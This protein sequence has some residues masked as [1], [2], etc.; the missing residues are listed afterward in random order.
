MKKV[1][2][3]LFSVLSCLQMTAQTRPVKGKVTDSRDGSVLLGVSVMVKGTTT[4]TT[5]NVDGVY[6]LN[7]ADNAT[8][9]FNFVG[10]EVLEVPVSGKST[11][12]IQ[13]NLDVKTLAEFEIST[14]YVSKRKGT[15]TGAIDVIDGKR[16]ESRPSG[17]FNHLLQGQAAGV[18]VM[19]NGGRPGAAPQIFIRGTGSINSGLAPLYIVDGQPVSPSDFATISQNDIESFNILKDAS[20]TAVYGSRG[21]NGVIL[22]TT[23]RGKSGK[24]TLDYRGFYGVTEIAEP[25]VRMMNTKERLDYEVAIGLRQANDPAI[26]ELLKSDYN[27]VKEILKPAL[28]QSHTISVRTGTDKTS[29]YMS[30]EYYDQ[31]GVYYDNDFSRVGARLNVDNTTTDWLKTGLNMYVGYMEEALPNETRNSTGNPGMMA[32]LVMPYENLRSES[33]NWREILRHGGYTNVRSNL[34]SRENDFTGSGNDHLKFLG[35]VFAEATIIPDLK[36]TTRYSMNLS[37]YVTKTFNQPLLAAADNGNATRRFSRW[38][39]GTWTNTLNYRKTFARN[40]SVNA[41]V[42]SEYNYLTDYDFTATA[43]NTSSPLLQ[44]FGTMLNPVSTGGSLS[45]YRMFGVFGNVN[46]GFKEKYYLD[47]SIRRDGSSK[48]GRNQ[49][50]G[51]FW[52]VGALWNAKSEPF[53]AQYE[54]ISDLRVRSSIGLTGND[55]IGFYPSYDLYGG[56]TYEGRPGLIPS[57][58][59]N[60][61]LTWEK[62]RKF[63]VGVDLGIHNRVSVTIDH[64]RE[65]TY[66]MV[67]DAP[68]SYLTGFTQVKGNMGK[69]SNNGVEF[70]VKG[71][72]LKNRDFALRVEGNLTYNKN[73]IRDLYGYRDELLGSGTGIL[74]KV[75]YPRGQ[76]KY[77]RFSRINPDNGLEL[78]LDK[79]GKETDKFDDADAVI[80][81]G[82]TM[83]A[84]WYGGATADFSWKGLG[85][86]MQWNFMEGKYSVNNTTAWL[87]WNNASWS[88][89]NRVHDLGEKMWKKPGDVAK[90]PKYGSGTQFDDR[91]LEDASFVRLRELTVYYNVPKNVLSKVKV[92]RSV[93]AYARANNLLTF[94]EWT[95]YDPEY[96]NNLELGIYPVS[97]SY[98]FGIDI[99]F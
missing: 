68:V 97:R 90:Y 5:T 86:F 15:I 61:D 49:Q 13:M 9:I 95:G 75:G 6:S 69:M 48:F 83:Y 29:I 24:A 32:Y 89:Y 87:V 3:M 56:T 96:F 80:Q 82:K 12:D 60:P 52:S 99:G 46:Y 76:F 14:G 27:Q 57:Q 93:R 38:N 74:T 64:Y 72:V 26:P 40:H 88:N 1:L 30:G 65:L 4:G 19:A 31:K 28:A 79:N 17:N 81:E 73:K 54:W 37:D 63:N 22:I 35:N 7:V 45:K 58:A 94:T 25:K 36:F 21:A 71:D 51:T 34:W 11:V 33:G 23:K 91:Y 2:L 18:Y 67:L 85:I 66:D 41:V 98:T 70:T 55:D 42:G 50:W 84:P 92:L 59:G 47:L 16:I 43:R 44:E 10:Y 53:I 77:N 78:W 62:R 8:L 39:N 20:A